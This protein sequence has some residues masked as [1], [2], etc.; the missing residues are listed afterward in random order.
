MNS[1]HFASLA[2]NVDVDTRTN[3]ELLVQK[4]LEIHDNME[5]RYDFV[6]ALYLANYLLFYR[7]R[8]G[9]IV[10]FSTHKGSMSDKILQVANLIKKQHIFLDKET[11]FNFTF[12]PPSLVFIDVDDIDI[13]LSILK[14]LWL[15]IT[16]SCVWIYGDCID[17]YMTSLR[18]EGW[19]K[20][21]LDTK[22]PYFGN[23]FFGR[24]CGLPNSDCL[25]FL[26]RESKIYELKLLYRKHEKNRNYK[27][28]I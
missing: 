5:R 28:S 24:E 20:T 3:R 27:R 26:I 16:T 10:G 8:P 11:F 22:P 13:V 25:N 21:N 23:N 12:D 17:N 18:D 19:W 15:K 6:D 14:N 7:H 9:P 1:Q 2:T 4:I